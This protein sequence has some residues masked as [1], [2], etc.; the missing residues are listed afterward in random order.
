MIPFENFHRESCVR[1]IAF[2]GVSRAEFKKLH[3]TLKYGTPGGDEKIIEKIE[4]RNGFFPFFGSIT[5]GLILLLT[6]LHQAIVLIA[7]FLAFFTMRA[8]Y[9]RSTIAMF[10]RI[11]AVWEEDIKKHVAQNLYVKKSGDMKLLDNFDAI[12]MRHGKLDLIKL[13]KTIG[14]HR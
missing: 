9:N 8:L 6:G 7:G 5:I 12:F 3:A 13:G 11:E 14:R 4:S 1:C 10:D 2:K